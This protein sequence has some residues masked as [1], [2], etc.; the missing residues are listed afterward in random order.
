MLKACAVSNALLQ[1]S[2]TSP[3]SLVEKIKVVRELRQDDWYWT[4]GNPP[5]LLQCEI[6]SVRCVEPLSLGLFLFPGENERTVIASS[7]LRL[8]NN[9]VS[10]KRSN[11]SYSSCAAIGFKIISFDA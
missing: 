10:T 7:S 5:R 11:V 9:S 4:H 8:K 6:I 1:M 2:D 3:F